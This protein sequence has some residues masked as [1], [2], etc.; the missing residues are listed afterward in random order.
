MH[1]LDDSARVL[2]VSLHCLALYHG[3]VSPEKAFSLLLLAQFFL[4]RSL[5]GT[6]CLLG[7]TDNC[8]LGRERGTGVGGGETARNVQAREREMTWI[9]ET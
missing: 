6:T 5:N 7:A 4:S 9:S 2:K 8:Q 1:Y 3:V